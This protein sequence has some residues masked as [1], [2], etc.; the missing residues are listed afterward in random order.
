MAFQNQRKRSK[1]TC[2]AAAGTLLL[3]FGIL[4]RLTGVST[5]ESA[6]KRAV[7]TIWEND[8]R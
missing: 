6:A 8:Q 1:R 2:V 7:S 5:F 4:S 3:E